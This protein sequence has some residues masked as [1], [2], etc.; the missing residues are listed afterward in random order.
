[1]AEGGAGF[2]C[3]NGRDSLVQCIFSGIIVLALTYGT[4]NM[5]TP[6]TIRRGRGRPPLSP[7]R[8]RVTLNVRLRPHLMERL[9]VAAH[10]AGHSLSREVEVRCEIYENAAAVLGER[11]PSPLERLLKIGNESFDKLAK[12]LNCTLLEAAHLQIDAHIAALP[13][14]HPR[15][16]SVALGGTTGDPST[17]DPVA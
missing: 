15:L 13:Y 10:A 2:V 8:H 3:P 12:S 16:A 7:E 9:E 11:Y 14:L 1:M 4:V 6:P 17:V 5:A